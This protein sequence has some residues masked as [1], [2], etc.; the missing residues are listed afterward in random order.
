[1]GQQKLHGSM[2]HRRLTLLWTAAAVVTL[3]LA[4]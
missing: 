4:G 3:L 1:M 2:F